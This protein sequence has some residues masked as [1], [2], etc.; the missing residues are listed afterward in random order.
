VQ[1]YVLKVLDF[2]FSEDIAPWGHSVCGF[3]VPACVQRT[4]SVVVSESHSRDEFVE[5]LG[6]RWQVFFDP[7]V[8]WSEAVAERPFGAGQIGGDPRDGDVVLRDGR[9]RGRV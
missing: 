9:E 6:Y 1:V 4:L 2:G 7:V 3:V 5:T 8:H